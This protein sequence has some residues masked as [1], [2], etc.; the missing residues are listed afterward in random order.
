MT[1]ETRPRGA[2][3]GSVIMKKRKSRISG[4]VTSAD[5]NSRPWTGPTC[6][7]VVMAWPRAASTA[8]EAAN[9]T[10]NATATRSMPSRDTMTSPPTTMMARASASPGPG[11]A[12]HKSSG[13]TRFEP[14]STK[15]SSS[16]ML[17]GLK[18]CRSPTRMTYFET[19]DTAA[20]AAKIH[21]PCRLHHWPCW[22]PATRRMNATLLPVSNALAGQTMAPRSQNVI[23]T[24]RTA[25][26]T[27]AVRICAIETLK[28]KMV[29]PRT[30][31]ER[32]T[33]ASC[34]RGSRL[35]GNVTR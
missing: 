6:H 3:F 20:V 15:H 7:R 9:V 2:V 11:R 4:E 18:T 32:M 17:D 27:M 29:W 22:V 23:T 31:N 10:Q 30:C 21:A 34:R 8:M 5:Q 28:P 14:R 24:S 1:C 26:V 33:P 13:L 35:D 25:A 12:H 19:T 16:P